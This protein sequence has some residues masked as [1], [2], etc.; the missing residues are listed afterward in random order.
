LAKTLE[1]RV[2]PDFPN[3]AE[4]LYQG[5]ALAPWVDY[6]GAHAA[7]LTPLHDSKR[8]TVTRSDLAQIARGNLSGVD[9]PLY[10]LYGEALS[11][12][13]RNILLQLFQEFPDAELKL[14]NGEFVFGPLHPPRFQA[15][16]RFVMETLH[17]TL[18]AFESHVVDEALSGDIAPQQYF[19][20]KKLG[21]IAKL[22]EGTVY[23]GTPDRVSA[24]Y[25][26]RDY[27]LE[28]K[29]GRVAVT[30]STV[31]DEHELTMMFALA[32]DYNLTSTDA[33]YALF[34]SA[35]DDAGR[36]ALLAVLRAHP[37]AKLKLK[38]GWLRLWPTEISSLAKEPT[39][40]VATLHK[41]LVALEQRA[42]SVPEVV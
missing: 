8:L 23:H 27:V 37:S 17:Q 6:R 20:R 4:G 41:V 3:H 25:A 21:R 13:Q 11:G 40:L 42:R 30:L 22:V 12:E 15:D 2:D 1:L 32:P 39:R 18:R 34:T 7:L 5:R 9:A 14:W 28:L 16:A 38:E 35:P 10:T 29:D 31:L 19:S 26:G 33:G 36:E 24:S